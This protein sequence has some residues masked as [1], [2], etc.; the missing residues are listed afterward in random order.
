[1]EASSGE[2]AGCVFGCRTGQ[3]RGEHNLHLHIFT[4]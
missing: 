3:H 1:L 2:V 4:S